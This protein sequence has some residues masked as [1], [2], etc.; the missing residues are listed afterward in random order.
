MCLPAGD[1]QLPAAHAAP[2]DGALPGILLERERDIAALGGVDQRLTR[3]EMQRAGILLVAGERDDDPGA[4]QSADA[5]ERFE[6]VENDDVSAL[7]VGAAGSGGERVETHEALALALEN[8]IEMTNQQQTLSLRSLVLGEE[9]AGATDCVG[10]SHPRRLK[11]DRREL[12]LEQPSHLADAS[13]VESAAAD[14]HRLLEE[15]DLLGLMGANVVANSL[16]DG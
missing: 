6:R 10:K 15:V 11:S 4:V 3:H 12:W 2:G 8:R 1:D 7:H 5:L 9:M 13:E 14:V 16:L